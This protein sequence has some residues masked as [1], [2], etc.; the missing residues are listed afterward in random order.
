MEKVEMIALINKCWDAI[1]ESK[2]SP[3]IAEER[4]GVKSYHTLPYQLFL[5]LIGS[6]LPHIS[7][8]SMKQSGGLDMK[9]DE[10]GDQ[11]KK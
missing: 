9:L 4:N 8:T 1:E 5:Q 3:I 11:W 6:H 7:I 2:A 10:P